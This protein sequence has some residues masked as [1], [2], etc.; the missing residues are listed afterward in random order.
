[1]CRRSSLLS[2]LADC[3]YSNAQGMMLVPRLAAS[4][5]RYPRSC[6]GICN[7][8]RAIG[9]NPGD[10]RHAMTR[11]ASSNAPSNSATR[12]TERYDP[13]TTVAVKPTT[14]PTI[15]TLTGTPNTC[16]TPASPLSSLTSAP[17]QLMASAT[18]SRPAA[19]RP[20]RC[21]TSSAAPPCA[22]RPSR[23]AISCAMNMN[24]ISNRF[25]SSSR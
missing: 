17:K 13:L 6:S 9:A 12:S 23:R 1:M 4:R 21:N 20:N 19:T 14:A 3:W 8:C 16:P 24:G 5:Y 2:T 10:A 11:N 18:S 22:P 15:V 25:G 7:A